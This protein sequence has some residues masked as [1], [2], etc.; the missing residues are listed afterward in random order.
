MPKTFN[1]CIQIF[2]P[3]HRL[4]FCFVYCFLCC[5]KV[6]KLRSLI[7]SQLFIFVFISITLING[8]KKILL[9]FVSKSV[10][11]VF[12][13]R[14]VTVPSLTFRS[15]IRCKFIF[16][17]VLLENVLISLFYMQLSSFPGTAYWRDCLFSV[18]YSCFHCPRLIDHKCMG[19]FL[20][21][22]FCSINLYVY[23]CAS[24]I[25]FWLCNFVV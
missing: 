24:I 8:S 18:L 12:F 5:A 11:P 4:S 23:F 19:L 13:S 22:L 3:F 25:Q 21:F 1:L 7:R 10:M 17:N 9:W 2:F 16:V 15:L 6:Y 20:G 14:S